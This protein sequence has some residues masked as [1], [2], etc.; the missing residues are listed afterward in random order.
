MSA[1]GNYEVEIY[2]QKTIDPIGWFW[3]IRLPEGMSYSG[4]SFTL[5][6]AKRKVDRLIANH[7]APKRSIY[8]EV[9]AGSDRV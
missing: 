7:G 9:P 5:S 8:F 2:K 6:G 4:Y 1:S 3:R